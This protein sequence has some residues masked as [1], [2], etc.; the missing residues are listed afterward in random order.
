[1]SFSSASYRVTVVASQPTA[2]RSATGVR[3]SGPSIRIV[4]DD[5]DRRAQADAAGGLGQGAEQVQQDVEVGRQEGVEIDE[6][7]AVEVGVVVLGVL[8]LGVVAQRL[9]VLGRTARRAP[10]RRPVTCPADAGSRSP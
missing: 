3:P 5:L 6:G 9:A 7:V 2:D 10:A 4:L 8:Q 1:M